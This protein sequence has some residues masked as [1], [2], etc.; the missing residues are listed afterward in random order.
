MFGNELETPSRAPDPAYF[1]KPYLNAVRCLAL[2]LLSNVSALQSRY[3]ADYKV[4]RRV[5]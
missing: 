5:W 2:Y 3:T 1:I 4:P